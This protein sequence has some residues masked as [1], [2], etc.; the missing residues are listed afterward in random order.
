[1]AV[2][3]RA[4]GSVPPGNSPANPLRG[5]WD[6]ARGR[7]IPVAVGLGLM[8]VVFIVD[9]LVSSNFVRFGISPRAADGLDGIVWAPFLHVSFAHLLANSVPFAVLGSVVA[10]SRRARF[11][12]VGVMTA[13]GSGLGVWLVSPTRSVT[14]GASGVVFG[15]FGYLLSRGLFDRKLSSVLI[16]VGSLVFYGGMLFGVLPNRAGVSWQA[17]LFGLFA[18]VGAAALL[19]GRSGR[20]AAQTV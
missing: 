11:L 5:A 20:T 16:G 1:M 12:V 15:L 10:V 19:D 14:V 8:W 7:L 18:G 4:G 17:H 6:T 13:I 3:T 9:V 2:T